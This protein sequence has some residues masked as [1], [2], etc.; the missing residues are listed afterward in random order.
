MIL[1]ELSNAGSD[2]RAKLYSGGI[3]GGKDE[4]TLT[5]LVALFRQARRMVDHAIRENC[6]DDG[7][8]HSYNLMKLD[9][10]SAQLS[11]LYEMLEGQ[12]AVLSSGLLS[13]EEALEVLDALRSS[14]IYRED[15]QSY[16]LYPD[17]E[18]PRFLDKNMVPQKTAFR[19]PL[20][21]QL[22]EDSDY[23]IIR[24][25]IHGDVH[26]NGQF[27]NVS[28]LNVALDRL[29][30]H[31]SYSK[32]VCDE[33]KSLNELF[34]QTFGHHNFTGRSGTFFAYEG[35]GSIYWHMVSKL[36]LA[37]MEQC[38]E[39]HE[40]NPN[41]QALGRLHAHYQEIRNGIG[42]TED[43]MQY[44]AF[45][46]DPYSHTPEGTGVRQPGMTG[47]V[48]E[49]VL[50]RWDELGIRIR[51]GQLSFDPRFFE[52]TEWL[53]SN[54]TLEFIDVIGCRQKMQVPRGSFAFTLCQVPIV[55]HHSNKRKL[56]IHAAGETIH[57]DEIVLTETETEKLFSRSDVITKIEVS[58]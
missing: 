57:R 44:G 1:D 52:S 17:R 49:D 26:F 11:H 24:Q 54:A 50:S 27:C 48:K 41:S 19:S 16:M 53:E 8:Y 20:L 6:R 2:F 55:F 25:D 10:G 42:L 38:I 34:E 46:A 5:S 15:Q 30:T 7:M 37:V 9:H 13:A 29:Q 51:K 4:F 22:I 23:S 39:E 58:F 40:R 33:R 56:V 32:L 18:L 47:Q 12:V 43:P 21:K 14:K 28:D 45:P 31:P 3:C 36:A 35:L